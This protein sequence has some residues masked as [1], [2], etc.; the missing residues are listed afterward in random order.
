MIMNGEKMAEPS[1][2]A[3]GG[4]PEPNDE[5]SEERG[6]GGPPTAGGSTPDPEVVARPV[7]RRFTAAYKE[8]ILAEVDGCDEAGQVGRI[9]RREG[10][11]SSNLT[12]WRRAR[13]Q[14]ALAAL[15]PKKR[16][17]K[18][19]EKN[20]LTKKVV[21]LERRNSQLEEEL[22]KARLIIDVQKKLASILDSLNEGER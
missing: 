11:Y 8:R 21:D 14:G 5:R 18:S 20:P 19:V 7:R 1:R 10:L 2:L 15:T 17:R 13:K 9:L 16:G 6:V 22:R 3:V 12:L 4:P